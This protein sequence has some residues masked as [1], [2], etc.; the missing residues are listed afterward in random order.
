MHSITKWKHFSVSE[1]QGKKPQK[2]SGVIFKVC[3]SSVESCL[4]EVMTICSSNRVAL[5]L[6]LCLV[7]LQKT[8]TYMHKNVLV[9]SSGF[10]SSLH[11]FWACCVPA[12]C[13]AGEVG[14]QHMS[15]SSLEEPT[16]RRSCKPKL[17][18]RFSPF[19]RWHGWVSCRNFL[20]DIGL[21]KAHLSYN[22]TAKRIHWWWAK[23][24]L[25]HTPPTH[26]HNSHLSTS[27]YTLVNNN[28]ILEPFYTKG[29]MI[30]KPKGFLNL[31]SYC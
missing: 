28:L 6:L 26:P 30:W 21:E 3:I 12:L 15:C 1:W 14:I 20:A 31:V 9:Y 27:L 10:S 18:L 25:F 13:C 11:S 7:S 24:W 19:R 5:K 4:R 29:N 16:H 2:N 22:R 23:V 17:E 8:N